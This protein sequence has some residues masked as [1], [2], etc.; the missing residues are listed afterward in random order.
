MSKPPGPARREAEPMTPP[1]SLSPVVSSVHQPASP[2]IV[3][4]AA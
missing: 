1:T 4:S 2:S 3:V